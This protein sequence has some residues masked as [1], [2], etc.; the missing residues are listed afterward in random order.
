MKPSE[1]TTGPRDT[2]RNVVGMHETGNCTGHYPLFR[3]MHQV[4]MIL[5]PLRGRSPSNPVLLTESLCTAA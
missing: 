4:R 5:L 1:R 3:S 2:V